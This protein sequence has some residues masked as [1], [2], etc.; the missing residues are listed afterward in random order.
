MTND[1][2]DTVSASSH[3][4]L[5][6]KP[7]GPGPSV[8]FSVSGCPSRVLPQKAGQDYKYLLVVPWLCPQKQQQQSAVA[9]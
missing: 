6:R 8:L 1:E 5:L 4:L 7:S 9:D 2:S 3:C